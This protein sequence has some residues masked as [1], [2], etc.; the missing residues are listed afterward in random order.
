MT[1]NKWIRR[2]AVLA[3]AGLLIPSAGAAVFFNSTFQPDTTTTPPEPVDKGCTGNVGVGYACVA[4]VNSF[5]LQ[6]WT[7]AAG[8]VDWVQ[9]LWDPAVTTVPAANSVDLNAQTPGTIRADFS[10][11]TAGNVYVVT[12]MYSGNPGDNDFEDSAPNDK[13]FTA[14]ISP[15]STSTAWWGQASFSFDAETTTLPNL[16][17]KTSSFAFTAQGTS[18]TIWLRS[19]T[20]GSFGAVIGMVDIS[21]AGQVPEPATYALMGA[22]LAALAF[23]RRR[24]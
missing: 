6:A 19:D 14:L 2:V 7:V 13:N 23:A 5:S 16:S 1:V 10:G 21:D 17:Y 8:S 12:L 11:L 20:A 24:R 9:F 15:S 3:L 4:A 18:G 22:G